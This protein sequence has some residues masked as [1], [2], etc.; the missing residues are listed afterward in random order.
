[1]AVTWALA[2]TLP[3]PASAEPA[4][5]ELVR[6]ARVAGCS[7]GPRDYV[8][9][10]WA[11]DDP[12]SGIFWCRRD[13]RH[14]AEGLVV[15]VVVER[16]KPRRLRCPASVASINEPDGLRILRDERTPLSWF[17]DRHAPWRKGPANLTTSGPVIDVGAEGSGSGEQWV[18]HRGVWLVRVYH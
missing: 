16:K 17:V 11:A 13:E 3:G 8:A 18:C 15:I 9:G 4:D 12:S 2:W 10:Y 7:T 6:L 14:V 5:G 1:M